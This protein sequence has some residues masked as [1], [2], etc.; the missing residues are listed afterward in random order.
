[1][2]RKVIYTLRQPTLVVIGK[3][4]RF[5]NG[6]TILDNPLLAVINLAAQ[7]SRQKEKYR[8]M[9]RLL[10]CDSSLRSLSPPPP[11]KPVCVIP[12]IRSPIPT[13]KSNY[14]QRIPSISQALSSTLISFALSLGIFYASPS[15]STALESVAP[16]QE[17][18]C[19][20]YDYYADDKSTGEAVTNEEIV[21]EAWQI[22][23]DSFL[24][25]G[26]HNWTPDSWLV[27]IIVKSLQKVI[28]LLAD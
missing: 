21:E 1:M 8:S 18:I 13:S 23:N 9:V 2:C 10:L 11:P 14:S 7:S 4:C 17:L 25:T 16:Q 27:C 5:S 19:R 20:E 12:P 26:R 15:H 3:Y 28:V 24:E 22:V 6:R